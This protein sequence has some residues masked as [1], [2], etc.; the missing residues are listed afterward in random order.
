MFINLH[1][2]SRYSD[3]DGIS[4]INEL[5]S[6]AKA[7]GATA[8]TTTDHGRISGW[9]EA[10]SVAKKLGIKYLP[11]VEGYVSLPEGDI[12]AT[13]RRAK[14]YHLTIFARNEKGIEFIYRLFRESTV[15]VNKAVFNRELLYSDEAKDLIIL[16]GCIG[17]EL[18]SYTIG[19]EGIKAPDIAAAEKYILE[20]KEIWGDAFF[21]EIGDHVDASEKAHSIALIELSKKLDVKLIATC[22]SH[23]TDAHEHDAHQIYMQ[24][25]KYGDWGVAKGNYSSMGESEALQHFTK[26]GYYQDS[27]REAMINTKLVSDMIEDGLDLPHASADEQ[28]DIRPIVEEAFIKMRKGTSYEEESRARLE[29]ELSVIINKGYQRYFYTVHSLVTYLKS[30]GVIIGPGRGSGAGSEVAY[31]MRITNVD[32]LKYDL[33]FERFLNFERDSPPDF[34]IDFQSYVTM[35]DG[36]QVSI[37]EVVQH[38]ATEFNVFNN[39]ALILTLTTEG[40]SSA[41]K[42]LMRSTQVP[43]ATANSITTSLMADQLNKCVEQPNL[44]RSTLESI[45][46]EVTPEIE[47][48]FKVAKH[49]VGTVKTS[50]IH[51][52]GVLLSNENIPVDSLGVSLFEYKPLEAMGFIKYDILAVDTLGH[53]KEAISLMPEDVAAKYYDNHGDI[54]WDED[55]PQVFKQIMKGTLTNQMVFQL[56]SAGMNKLIQGI[57]PKSIEDIALINAFFRPGPLASGLPNQYIDRKF[58]NEDEAALRPEE[59][60]IREALQGGSELGVLVY[61][62]QAMKLAQVLSGFSLNEADILRAA[63]GKKDQA[64]IKVVGE[65]FIRRF[66]PELGPEIARKV[67]EYI[68]PFGEYAF[69]KSHSV[70]YSMISYVTAKL[71]T[72]DAGYYLAAIKRMGAGK[73]NKIVSI[74]A[75]MNIPV[76]AARWPAKLSTYFDGKILWMAPME[77]THEWANIHEFMADKSLGKMHTQIINFGYW[78]ENVTTLLEKNSGDATMSLF[79]KPK[80]VTAQD[81][82]LIKLAQIRSIG[83][84]LGAKPD[85]NFDNMIKRFNLISEKWAEISMAMD[86]RQKRYAWNKFPG[87]DLEWTGRAHLVVCDMNKYRNVLVSYQIGQEVLSFTVR[88]FNKTFWNLFSAKK[89]GETHEIS[90]A[91]SYNQYTQELEFIL[92][93]VKDGN[94]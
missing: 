59:L 6:K 38:W 22:D 21:L 80:P 32:P 49:I 35:E 26:L 56:S 12:K 54:I 66:N 75:D 62:E 31:L 53:I 48:A 86:Q 93:D 40:V 18:A 34:D 20:A 83:M 36:R 42:G 87:T 51:A 92:K 74:A 61:Q 45:S 46:I 4:K 14:Y 13:S 37:K 17:G 15:E 70:A 73:S 88:K 41:L 19:I 77:S 65:E 94:R 67:W 90:V 5:A 81:L 50:G 91:L 82:E 79:N 43:Y 24:S 58:G 10:M 27:W 85:S 89:P 30:I 28:I 29:M 72:Y 64:K 2:H 57:K 3:L 52:S 16:S 55:D 78:G 9:P 7:D 11:A 33:L 25:S 44:L 84:Y 71:M 8:F 60:V 69:N 23:Y 1:T 68:I 39:T 47:E 63:I 76:K